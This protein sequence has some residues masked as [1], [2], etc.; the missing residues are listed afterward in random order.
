MHSVVLK[1]LLMFLL[2]FAIAMLVALIIFW[3]RK[4]LTSVRVES[5]FN[6]SS[7]KKMRRAIRIHQ[8]HEA[9]IHQLAIEIERKSFPEQLNYHLGVTQELNTDEP[10]YGPLPKFRIRF[11]RKKDK[12]KN[13]KN[14]IWQKAK[15]IAKSS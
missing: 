1:T 10:F 3:I 9:V 15:L 2:S 4:L 8:F 6:E 13:P 12:R 7:R 11:K 5:L 14:T